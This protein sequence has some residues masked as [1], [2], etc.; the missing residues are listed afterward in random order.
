M[1]DLDVLTPDER[2]R[3]GVKGYTK[4]RVLKWFRTTLAS[5]IHALHRKRIVVVVDKALK[6]KPEEAVGALVAGGCA[7]D[8]QVWVMET[9]IA[10]YCSPLGNAI[11][12]EWKDRV[13]ADQPASESNYF[14]LS[15]DSGMVSHPVMLPIIIVNVHSLTAVLMRHGT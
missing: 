12:H 6:K 3:A 11:W 2:K 14:E 9:N 7:D 15:N 5:N 10:K 1:L 8:V 4:E 13:R